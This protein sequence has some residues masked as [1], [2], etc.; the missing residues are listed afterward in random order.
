MKPIKVLNLSLLNMEY[1][2]KKKTYKK[3]RKYRLGCDGGM[4]GRVN[5]N[6]PLITREHSNGFK[7]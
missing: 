2:K 1:H 7:V 5:S 4:I 3:S 6:F